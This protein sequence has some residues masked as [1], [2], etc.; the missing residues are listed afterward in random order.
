MV[1]AHSIACSIGLGTCSP[2]GWSCPARGNRHRTR[3]C[4]TS[5]HIARHNSRR[6][7][8]VCDRSRTSRDQAAQCS[9][10][11]RVLP[12]RDSAA[13]DRRGDGHRA[14]RTCDRL[15]GESDLQIAVRLDSLLAPAWAALA[16]PHWMRADFQGAQRAAE[17]AIRADPFGRRLRNRST[18]PHVLRLL[19]GSA[20]QH[21]AGV[22]AAGQKYRAPGC[23]STVSYWCMHWMRRASETDPIP[24]QHGHWSTHLNDWMRSDPGR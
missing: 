6:G 8:I 14:K 9:A 5:H 7:A 12:A 24:Q 3:T 11:P 19:A 16:R 4:R 10:G 1:R 23:F 13:H 21:C 2:R 18:G 20:T 15:G 22:D 17:M